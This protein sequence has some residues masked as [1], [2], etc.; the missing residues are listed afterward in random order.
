MD[1]KDGNKKFQNAYEY[2]LQEYQDQ[3]KNNPKELISEL[4]NYKNANLYEEAFS[5]KTLEKLK[6][7]Y[8]TAT[9]AR[10]KARECFI[11]KILKLIEVTP[12]TCK[13][14][15]KWTNLFDR[16]DP[17]PGGASAIVPEIH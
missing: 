3:V 6:I 9:K 13:D 10:G 12:P 14:G 11:K 17:P 2:F 7:D 8:E 15:R 5:L 4:E 1:N 16:K